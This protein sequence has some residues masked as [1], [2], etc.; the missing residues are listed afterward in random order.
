VFLH[1]ADNCPTAAN[2]TQ[3]NSG[4]LAVGITGRSQR[5]ATV[6]WLV[7]ATA[8]RDQSPEWRACGC[9]T[10]VLSLQMAILT[11]TLVTTARSSTQSCCSC[12]CLQSV[13]RS[14]HCRNK[15][16]VFV[17]KKRSPSRFT[18]CINTLSLTDA[19]S[20]NEGQEDDDFDGQGNECDAVSCSNVCLLGCTPAGSVDPGACSGEA[21]GRCGA[22]WEALPGDVGCKRACAPRCSLHA[23]DRTGLLHAARGNRLCRHASVARFGGAH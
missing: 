9:V 7:C 20:D 6:P 10:C 15:F 16:Y 22:G 14:C 8:L 17:H 4:P 18:C 2:P 13:L 1:R 3:T 5:G 23:D 19:C 21:S 11:A 12:V